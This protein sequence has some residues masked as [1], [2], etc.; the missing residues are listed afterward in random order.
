MWIEGQVLVVHSN[1]QACSAY[2]Y[3][4]SA[5]SGQE[6]NRNSYLKA[7]RINVGQLEMEQIRYR[8]WI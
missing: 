7:L 8:E 2:E 6:E 3:P 4:R 5:D 1:H